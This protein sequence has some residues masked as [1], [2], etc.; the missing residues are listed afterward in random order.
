MD[1]LNGMHLNL[2]DFCISY[3]KNVSEKALRFDQSLF[4]DVVAVLR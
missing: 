2:F 3:G 1:W 4:H